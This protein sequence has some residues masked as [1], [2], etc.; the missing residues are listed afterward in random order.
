MLDASFLIAVEKSDPR[1]TVW[2]DEAAERN[3]PMATVA[4]I[5]AEVW[6]GG[7]RQAPLSKFLKMIPVLSVDDAAARAAGR[8]LGATGS[9]STVDATLVVWAARRGAAVLTSDPKDIAPMAAH[10]GVS[11]FLFST[12]SR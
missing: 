10:L 3:I 6:R 11:M 5:V 4:T 1:C 8:L 7:A 12:R 2:V 9:S